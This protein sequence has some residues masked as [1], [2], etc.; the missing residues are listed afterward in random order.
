VDSLGERRV[1]RDHDHRNACVARLGAYGAQRVDPAHA[2]Q[3][4]IEDNQV[5]VGV[6]QG[7]QSRLRRVLG[8]DHMAC[9]LEH[10]GQGPPEDIVVLGGEAGEGGGVCGGGFWAGLEDGE[11]SVVV[12]GVGTR[13]R[14]L[15]P[16]GESEGIRHPGRTVVH[17]PVG[18]STATLEGDRSRLRIAVQSAAHQQFVVGDLEN[19][20]ALLATLPGRRITDQA[21]RISAAGLQPLSASPTANQGALTIARP[22]LFTLLLLTDDSL[23]VG[24][25]GR[26]CSELRAELIENGERAFRVEWDA[27]AEEVV[28]IQAA[29]REIGVGG[30]RLLTTLAVTDRT[31]HR[32]RAAWTNLK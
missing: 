25:V 31:G 15:D 21:Y 4:N 18:W 22:G 32:A 30:R 13:V 19:S 6:F 12:M 27:P 24:Y 23:V 16:L 29:Q 2:G 28:W 9:P 8:R 3:A 5:K 20:D 7:A 10:H 26:R 14:V 17:D 1:P 11:E